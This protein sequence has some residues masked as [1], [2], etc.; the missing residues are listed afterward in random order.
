MVSAGKGDADTRSPNLEARYRTHDRVF[1]RLYDR[2]DLLQFVREYYE[3]GRATYERFQY[4]Q[5]ELTVCLDGTRLL[6]PA[7]GAARPG[8]A[9]DQLEMQLDELGLD[10]LWKRQ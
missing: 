4:E 9:E 6:L 1:S 10:G 2:H 7:G 8:Q 3:H 5:Y